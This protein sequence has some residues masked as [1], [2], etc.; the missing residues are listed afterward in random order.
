[1]LIVEIIVEMIKLFF[2]E[3]RKT[4]HNKFSLGP[5]YFPRESNKEVIFATTV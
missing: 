4:W 3:N 5:C 2:F 1:M